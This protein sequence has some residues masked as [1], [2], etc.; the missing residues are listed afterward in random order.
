MKECYFHVLPCYDKERERGEGVKI[1]IF[2][3]TYILS[4]PFKGDEVATQDE[5]VIHPSK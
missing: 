2:L 1:Q 4:M 3:K 5:T